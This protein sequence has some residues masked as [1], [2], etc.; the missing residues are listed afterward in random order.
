MSF[1]NDII[2]VPTRDEFVDKFVA[3]LRLATFPVASWHSG[4]FQKHFVETESTMF[5]DLSAL[6]RNVAKGGMIRSAAEIGDEW[7][8]LCA[9]DFFD[10]VRKPAVYT[11]GKWRLVDA[12][13]IGPITIQPGSFWVA[14]ADKTFR[15]VNVDPAPVV[16]PLDGSA[17]LTLQAE[18]PGSQWNVGVGA[19]TELL[20]PQPGLVGAN[21]A[22][23]TG[24]WITQ[25]GADKES[26]ASLILRCLSKWATLGSGANDGA[27]LY[28]A[29]SASPEITFPR[30]YSPYG[31]A[32]RVVLRGSAGPVSNAALAAAA[33]R[34][35]RMRPLGVPDVVML[36]ATVRQELVAGTLVP[37]R[38]TDP[39]VA[40]G[41]A[42]A[43][44]D[45]LARETKIGARVSRE[46]II[47]ALMDTQ[48]DD[49]A[50]TAPAVD[51]QLS[52]NE[53]WVP[54]YALDVE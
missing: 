49:C 28:A 30:V 39:A 13:G 52:A 38:N 2:K 53:V 43:A 9:A 33:A 26:S 6:I 8:D 15:Y 24:T 20:T 37:P 45:K 21:E 19:L 12:E 36:N 14:N 34:V 32:V 35:E 1:W 23:D 31:G 5:A 11:Q 16:L 46:K 40:I 47:W 54:S 25:Q 51:F 4:S 10:E 50:L 42:Q 44:V 22:L 41:A 29:M 7:V 27:Y 17:T 18:R 48:L 3:L